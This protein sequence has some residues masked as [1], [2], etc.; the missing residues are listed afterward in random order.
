MLWA[1]ST[2]ETLQK[3]HILP[4]L[5]QEFNFR[6]HAET[7]CNNLSVTIIAIQIPFYILAYMARSCKEN[8]HL[9]RLIAKYTAMSVEEKGPS[10]S[11]QFYF[12][13]IQMKCRRSLVTK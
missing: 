3:H 10:T 6:Y 7:C 12:A 8:L 13:T 4:L 9:G 1:P 2:M 5:R 11:K